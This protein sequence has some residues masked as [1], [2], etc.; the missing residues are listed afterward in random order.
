MNC[1]ACHTDKPADAFRR[2]HD[3]SQMRY[4]AS[5]H[6]AKRRAQHAA[7][8]EHRNA[9]VREAYAENRNGM[10]DKYAAK[11]AEKY[12]MTG[13]APLKAWMAEN[14]ERVKSAARA[15]MKR[16]AD[17]LTDRYVRVLLSQHSTVLTPSDIPPSLIEV[18]RVQI[19]IE[20]AIRE[21]CK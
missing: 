5:C 13:R 7:S 10:R 12:E 11:R 17:A 15:K 6:L 4:C 19:Q 2:H 21:Q 1:T 3:G 14:P 20:R 9:L 18:K 16:K 8:R